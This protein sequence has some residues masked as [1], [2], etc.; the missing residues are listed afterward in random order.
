MDIS[1]PIPERNAAG[2]PLLNPL[3]FSRRCDVRHSR[4]QSARFIFP[5]IACH[6]VLPCPRPLELLSPSFAFAEVPRS[7]ENPNFVR[8]AERPVCLKFH[9]ENTEG[10]PVELFE[11]LYGLHIMRREKWHELLPI[12]CL[13][14][15]Q[16]IVNGL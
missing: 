7:L 12:A 4:V 15:F 2:F 16:E 10:S 5:S 6:R 8:V 1:L 14:C 13:D 9:A 3:L 11:L